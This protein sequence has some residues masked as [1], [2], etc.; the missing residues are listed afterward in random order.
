[1]LKIQHVTRA[2]CEK[3]LERL[4]TSSSP[5]P[6]VAHFFRN[7]CELFAALWPSFLNDNGN[8]HVC[9]EVHPILVSGAYTQVSWIG[10]HTNQLRFHDEVN[11]A[12]VFIRVVVT[13]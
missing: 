7:K 10:F 11:A 9:S 2:V 5:Q 13:F 1:M 6:H 12:L 3:A 8:M 4:P